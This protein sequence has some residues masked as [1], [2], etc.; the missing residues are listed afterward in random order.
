MMVN[1]PVYRR[2][3]AV[4]AFWWLPV[5]LA[6]VAGCSLPALKFSKIPEVAVR[7]K[8]PTPEKRT[9]GKITE[10]ELQTGIMDFA[11]RY[12][13]AVWGALDNLKRAET[14]PQ[15][16]IAA[17]YWKVLYSSAAMGIAAGRNPGENLLDMVVFITLGRMSVEEYWVPQ[18]FGG[19]GSPL[20][21]AYRR[22]ETDMGAM[23]GEVLSPSQQER[24]RDLIRHWRAAH[25]KQY[26]VSQ[27]RWKDLG[28]LKGE[29]S[30]AYFKQA[31]N[32]LVEVEKAYIKVDSA[33]L[34]SERGIFYLKHM[35]EIV[36]L[37]TEL[38]LDQIANTP[39]AGQFLG[40]LNRMA[41][42]FDSLA[43]TTRALPQKIAAERGLAVSQVTSWLE[44]QRPKLWQDLEAQEPRLKGLLA[45]LK[46]T[47]ETGNSLSQSMGRTTASLEKLFD[48]WRTDKDRPVEIADYIKTLEKISEAAR[49]LQTLIESVDKLAATPEDRGGLPRLLGVLQQTN[50][51]VKGLM[52]HAFLL[53]ALLLVLLLSGLVAALLA[54]R[55]LSERLFRKKG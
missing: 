21:D 32:L 44:A 38:I 10:A 2:V 27:V 36:T 29:S 18:V 46:D 41:R 33:F 30:V 22:L 48:R 12:R 55:Y 6:S 39:E 20:L 4:A 34:L 8:T 19:K 54:Y 53:G 42:S 52:N 11:E 3:L 51:E 23:A 24:L 26:Q 43:Q 14:E 16:R 50:A 35:P 40:N 9:P 5:L 13:L 15:K 49:G 47:L 45:E 31:N 17:Q 37:Q 28:L 1:A 7:I 25:P